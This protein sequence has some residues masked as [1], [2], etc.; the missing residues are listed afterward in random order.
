MAGSLCC[1]FRLAYFSTPPHACV[2]CECASNRQ[3]PLN[4]LRAVRAFL[5]FPRSAPRGFDCFGWVDVLVTNTQTE[6]QNATSTL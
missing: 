1:C 4:R 2:Q 6:C 3:Q 5:S